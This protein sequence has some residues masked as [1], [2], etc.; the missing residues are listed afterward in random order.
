VSKVR[1]KK[2]E[3]YWR[4]QFSEHR[5]SGKSIAEFCRRRRIPLHQFHWW[6]RRL[7]LLDGQDEEGQAENEP[8]FVPVR[9]P[10]FSFSVGLI[11][12]V[13][14]SGCVVRIPPRFDTDALR[15]VLD[16]LGAARSPEA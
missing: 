16:T 12:V 2:K 13:H 8:G 9:L 6:K 4:R 7:S 5:G 3:A 1:D 14:P 11:E 10:A 15:R